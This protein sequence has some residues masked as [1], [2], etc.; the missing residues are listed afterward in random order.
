MCL[1]REKRVLSISPHSAWGHCVPKR[2]QRNPHTKQHI[3]KQRLYDRRQEART[4]LG[5]RE[6]LKGRMA[7]AWLRR[8]RKQRLAHWVQLPTLYKRPPP[9]CLSSGSGSL[10][11]PSECSSLGGA[12]GRGGG[13]EE[14]GAEAE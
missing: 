12:R 6:R 7:S 14:E 1:F 10:E 13:R 3:N 5:R 8:V 4:G 11:S 2:T 9:E